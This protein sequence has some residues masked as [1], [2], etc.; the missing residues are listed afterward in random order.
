MA[1]NGI[2]WSDVLGAAET[3]STATWTVPS[4]LTKGTESIA[5]PNTTVWLSAGAA[6]TIYTVE[7]K[8]VTSGGR[9]FDRSFEIKVEQK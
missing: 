7:C 2:D 5:S 4:G 1:V 8:V 6:G 3:V 9:T